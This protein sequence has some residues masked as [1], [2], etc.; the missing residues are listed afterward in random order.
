MLSNKVVIWVSEYRILSNKVAYEIPFETTRH[1]YPTTLLDSGL[2]H[3]NWLKQQRHRARQ[4]P[5]GAAEG[6]AALLFQSI[7]VAQ[8]WIP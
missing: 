1:I 8:A 3:H 6:G 4:R 2:G 7:M 5:V